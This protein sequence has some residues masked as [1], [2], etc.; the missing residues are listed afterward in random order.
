MANPSGDD[1][2]RLPRYPTRHW[3]EGESLNPP[4][5][6][7]GILCDLS[8]DGFRLHLDVTIPPSTPIETKCNIS[9]IGLQLRGKVVWTDQTG[10][11]ILHGIMLTGFGSDEDALFHRLYIRRLARP[12]PIQSAPIRV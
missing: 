2:R 10:Q 11:G 5:S 9:G 7:R 1:R 4:R 8:A 3:F 6:I 12:T